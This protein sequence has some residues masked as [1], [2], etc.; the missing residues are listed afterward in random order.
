ML[1]PR[2]SGPN[3]PGEDSCAEAEKMKESLIAVS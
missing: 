1:L 3:N 2:G